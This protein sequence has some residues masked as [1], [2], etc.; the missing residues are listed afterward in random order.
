MP[1]PTPPR[2][3]WLTAQYVTKNI[4]ILFNTL[5]SFNIGYLLKFSVTWVGFKPTA[6][7]LKASSLYTLM[8]ND[9]SSDGGMNYACLTIFS[10]QNHSWFYWLYYSVDLQMCSLFNCYLKTYDKHVLCLSVRLSVSVCPPPSLSFSPHI[11]EQLIATGELRQIPWSNNAIISLSHIYKI[12]QKPILKHLRHLYKIRNLTKLVFFKSMTERARGM[13]Q[14]L[15][16]NNST[17]QLLTSKIS[18]P[19]MSSTPM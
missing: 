8:K 1:N 16:S 6:Y 4:F 14:I 2:R 10:N 9:Y 7:S 12:S 19:A 18:K 17:P 15:R 3:N 5:S 13:R 11:Q